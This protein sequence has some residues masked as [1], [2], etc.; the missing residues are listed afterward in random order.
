MASTWI[1]RLQ[2]EVSRRQFGAASL[3]LLLG[4]RQLGAEEAS[5]FAPELNTAKYFS[6]KTGG[7]KQFWADVWLFHD[8]RIQR[9]ALTHHCRLLDGKN[10][11]LHSGTFDECREELDAIRSRANLPAMSGRAVVVLHGLFRHRGTMAKLHKAL[12]T[13]GGWSVFSVGYPT[14]RGSVVGRYR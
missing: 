1:Q 8:F 10:C 2:R 7:G 12:A 9:N 13:A 3:G 11:R 4:S 6:S 5:P 14:T